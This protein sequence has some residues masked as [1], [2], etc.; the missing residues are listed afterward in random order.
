[1]QHYAVAEQLPAAPCQRKRGLRV[2]MMRTAQLCEYQKR[3]EFHDT[4]VSYKQQ[5]LE[6]E[7]QS[8]PVFIHHCDRFKQNDRENHITNTKTTSE[9]MG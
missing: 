3:A 5:H 7:K 8:K 9:I 4:R 6:T 1:M 2:I